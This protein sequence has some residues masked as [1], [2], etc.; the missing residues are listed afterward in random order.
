M[1]DELKNLQNIKRQFETAN[2]NWLTWQRENEI[3]VEPESLL[4]ELDKTL[5]YQ[6][7]QLATHYWEGC[8]IL[9]MKEEIS[10]NYNETKAIKKQKKRWRRYAKIAPCFVVTFHSLPK[11]FK[12]WEGEDKPL[13][14]FFDLL[15]VDEA[16]QVSPEVAGASFGLAKKALV[17]GDTLQIEP[18]WSLNKEIDAGNLK[19]HKLIEKSEDADSIHELGITATQG[20]VMKIAQRASKYQK[21]K[22]FERG[23]FL[24]EHYRCV[25]EV[26]GYCNEL[27]YQDKLFPKRVSIENYPLP[28]VGYAP[29]NGQSR[30]INGSRENA[31]EA[32]I[33]AGWIADNETFLTDIYKGKLS[34]SEIVGIVT[35]FRRQ[36]NLVKSK[37]EEFGVTE[38]ITVGSVHS[39]QGAERP[40]V[41]FSP[42]HGT[43]DNSYFFERNAKPNMLN[44]AVSRAK[45]C[46][47]VFGNMAIFNSD[48]A[49]KPAK[50]LARYLF[51]DA[52]N[53]LTNIRA[54]VR[55]ELKISGNVYHLTT[56][57]AHRQILRDAF[58]Q[59]KK[60]I[61]IVSPFLTE[62]AIR[63]DDLP[64][65]TEKSKRN[66]VQITVYT[67]PQL[68]LYNGV[69][70][71]SFVQG[72][73]LLEKS[74]AIVKKVRAEH[75]KT[76]MID[77]TT[78]VEGSFNW[79]S[80][81]RDKN[82]PYQ[83]NERSIKYTGSKIASE[84]EKTI[85]ETESR[86]ISK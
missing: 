51:A 68:N 73:I 70:K 11:F 46:F 84:I 5:R 52:E 17:V 25:P 63:S 53:E 15:I 28:H 56:L 59:A 41:I 19:R 69:P 64:E 20:N 27:A 26:I 76:L 60:E 33:L 34:L 16:G 35:P 49:R 36:A 80:A 77:R 7:F 23:M 4:E 39:L 1:L 8:W 37:L 30:K 47:L 83:R 24:T 71:Q 29:I 74:G 58:L 75:S 72:K 82:H 86:I 81:L 48:K 79:L 55:E 12:A 40:I 13:I 31:D 50:L 38:K 21:F 57:E 78:L 6:A 85:A 54:K 9:E 62:H 43:N 3:A 14:E 22:D 67:D 2:Q 66:G 42:V 61:V 32:E 65:L 10:Q 45:D 18:V 44:V